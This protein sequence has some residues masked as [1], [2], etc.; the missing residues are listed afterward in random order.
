[1]R[2]AGGGNQACSRGVPGGSHRRHAGGK[3]AHP[4][5]QP[6]AQGPDWPGSQQPGLHPLAPLPF[7]KQAAL[8]WLVDKLIYVCMQ[9]Y[10]PLQL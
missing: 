3:A 6:Q 8:P 4:A 1:M 5:G 2:G 7:A 10:S 9:S